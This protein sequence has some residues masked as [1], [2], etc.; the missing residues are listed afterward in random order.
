M[1]NIRYYGIGYDQIGRPIAFGPVR[2]SPITASRDA[3]KLF[4]TNK[5]V[6]SIAVVRKD[7]R[8]LRQ[9]PETVAT[10]TVVPAAA[11]VAAPATN[12][13]GGRRRNPVSGSYSMSYS[14]PSPSM[15]HT[16]KKI[17]EY[18]I[19]GAYGQGW[20]GVTWEDTWSEARQRLKEYNDNEPY[21]HRIVKRRVN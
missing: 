10:A 12:P 11:V 6:Y 17:Y 5:R 7:L 8:K 4:I 19:Q 20:E 21:P 15:L 16:V 13:C 9:N 18:E 14:V 2:M 3:E 1:N